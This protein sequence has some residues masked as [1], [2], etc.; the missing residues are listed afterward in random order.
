MADFDLLQTKMRNKTPRDA[1]GRLVACHVN[2][3]IGSGFGRLIVAGDEHRVDKNYMVT[4]RCDCGVE[5][6]CRVAE[7]KAGKKLQCGAHRRVIGEAQRK[8]IG[9]RNRRHGMCRTAEYSAWVGMKMRCF[10]AK[11]D[12]YSDYGG[13]GITVHPAWVES[14]DAFF[15]YVGSKPSSDHSLDRINVDGNYEPGNVRWANPS[16]QMRNRRPHV[17][18]PGTRKGAK[19]L[20]P[21]A[22]FIP[23]PEARTSE[24]HNAKHGM[25]KSP[26]YQAWTAMKKRCC[27]PEHT[28]Y[29]NYGGRG[30]TVWAG[31]LDNFPAF[32]SSVGM[33]PKGK[34]SLDRID[35]QRGYEPGNVRWSD[36][37]TQNRNRRPFVIASSAS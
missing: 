36:P 16:V 3:E 28:A 17:M 21:A 8:K 12:R 20:P 9:I 1:K 35:N 33:R 30:V 26:E 34:Y 15:Q 27:N 11:N 24:H 10:N 18:R 23:V 22:E 7:L 37:V 31:W 25:S 4:C 2:L 29:R 13:R 14:F 6:V 32:L 5:I 19:P